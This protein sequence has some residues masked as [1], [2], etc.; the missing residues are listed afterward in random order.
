M[1]VSAGAVPRTH[2]ENLTMTQSAHVREI[3][4]SDFQRMHKNQYPIVICYNGH[5]HYA[6][7]R[8]SD[9][10]NY[11]RWK[12]EKQLGPILSARFLVIEEVDRSKLPQNVLQQVNQVEATIVQALPII[13]PHSNAAHLRR[14]VS[15]QPQRGPV[16]SQHP[17]HQVSGPYT[18]SDLPSASTS[19]QPPPQPPVADNP[20]LEDS[21]KKKKEIKERRLCL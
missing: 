20:E 6:P 12:M 15:D 7:T 2:V 16:F 11:Y 13:S 19:A 18:P 4:P 5:D 21:G 3:H 1:I 17:A 9:P 8:S 14:I 10:Q